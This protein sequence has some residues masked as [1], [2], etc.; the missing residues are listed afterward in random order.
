M[1]CPCNGC[2]PPRR[3]EAC[4]DHCPEYAEWIQPKLRAREERALY[5]TVRQD[6][7]S[8]AGKASRRKLN[9]EKLRGHYWTS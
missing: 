6:T 3:H 7:D 2:V 4:H 5:S 8:P 9:K 1:K